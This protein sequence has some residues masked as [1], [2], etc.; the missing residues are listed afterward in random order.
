MEYIRCLGWIGK[1]RPRISLVYLAADP[2]EKNSFWVH[3]ELYN[4][5]G[6]RARVVK[7]ST[8]Q[9]C[10]SPNFFRECFEYQIIVIYQF[11]EKIQ[12]YFW[13]YETVSISQKIS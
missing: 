6:H 12:L 11:L 5:P 2:A 7:L 13:N 10:D 3:G 8:F 4:R 9:L 1:F